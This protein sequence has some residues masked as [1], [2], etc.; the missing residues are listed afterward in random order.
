MTVT[1]AWHSRAMTKQPNIAEQSRD[2]KIDTGTPHSPASP[3][4]VN[5]DAEGTSTEQLLKRAIA[6]D[7]D[8]Y[9]FTRGTWVGRAKE[10]L[11]E[12]IDSARES[13]IT[14]T[15]KLITNHASN[16]IGFAQ[17][18][19]DVLMYVSTGATNGQSF[20]DIPVRDAQGAIA[21][22][23]NGAPL[24]RKLDFKN[25]EDLKRPWNFVWRPI[26]NLY[27]GMIQKSFGGIGKNALDVDSYK[28]FFDLKAATARDRINPKTLELK[29]LS[30]NWGVRS[31]LACVVPMTFALLL[32]EKKQTP[33][34]TLH[35][36]QQRK[37]HFATYLATQIGRG[38]LF[39]P[40]TAIQLGQKLLHP[41]ED[42]QIGKYKHQFVGVG[43]F[44][45]GVFSFLSAFRQI[46]GKIPGQQIYMKNFWQAGVGVCTSIAGY[47]TLTGINAEQA[48]RGFGVGM[49]SRN[50]F[51]PVNV[52][53]RFKTLEQGAVPY[54]AAQATFQAK[55]V[56]ALLYG[57]SEVENGEIVDQGAS[58]VQQE[59]RKRQLA[60]EPQTNDAP[61]A[62]EHE[63][64]DKGLAV[65]Q[66]EQSHHAPHSIN[67]ASIPE[68]AQAPHTKIMHTKHLGAAMPERLAAS[69]NREAVGAA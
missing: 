41:N 49:I 64:H 22:N 15:P 8:R 48:W 10:S 38:A 56:F 40:Q 35:E 24:V 4:S 23:A 37:D 53:Q 62:L 2:D 44:L 55:N 60:K 11:N 3:A 30:N 20:W 31:G 25:I 61:L 13:A 21:K 42:Q 14:H 9:D 59:K 36:F 39:V 47:L 29:P 6:E 57:G 46:K 51:L 7:N 69:T 52:Y 58:L 5:D 33:E 66:A 26:C 16:F 12:K 18:V 50:F 65:V 28:T 27:G 68:P 19:A 54:A 45:G 43:F 63:G 17:L 1:L 32:P 67:A 34:E